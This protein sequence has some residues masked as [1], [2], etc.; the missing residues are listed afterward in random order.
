MSA[1][2]ILARLRAM[3]WCV[4]IHN[5]YRVAGEARRL[6]LLT[7]PEGSYVKGEGTGEGTALSEAEAAIA[8]LRTTRTAQIHDAF[9]AGWQAGRTKAGKM[10]ANTI[11]ADTKMAPMPASAEDDWRAAIAGNPAWR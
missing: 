6:W 10:N 5:D 2:S 8:V 11:N 9:V 1:A 7:K 3:G 4:G